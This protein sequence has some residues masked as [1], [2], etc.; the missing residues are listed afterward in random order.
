FVILL[1]ACAVL[2]LLLYGIFDAL[3]EKVGRKTSLFFLVLLTAAVVW[4]ITRNPKLSYSYKARWVAAVASGMILIA[5]GL[6]DSHPGADPLFPSARAATA[7][8][9][10]A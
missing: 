4:S 1:A 8:A 10:L 5:I 3:S 9:R 2:C 7:G 6:F